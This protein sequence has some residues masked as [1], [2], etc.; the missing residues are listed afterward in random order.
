[1]EY[2]E[3]QNTPIKLNASD[4]EREPLTWKIIGGADETRLFLDEEYQLTFVE[5]N[6]TK[7]FE[8]P[9]SDNND[10]VYEIILRVSDGN[11]SEDGNFTISITNVNDFVPEILNL[12]QNATT[13]KEVMRMN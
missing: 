2:A 1:M 11:A 6:G 9:R 7:D 3:N 4:V 8:N 12:E 5:G 13:T 10:S